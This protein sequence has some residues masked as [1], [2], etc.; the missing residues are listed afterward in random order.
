MSYLLKVRF[1]RNAC[2]KAGGLY[3]KSPPQ[4]SVRLRLTDIP[5]QP[6]AHESKFSALGDGNAAVGAGPNPSEAATC[7][8]GVP[9]REALGRLGA[10]RSGAS[11][12]LRG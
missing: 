6:A 12:A 1:K 2:S 4:T 5:I 10:R 8:G 9:W 7:A 11:P 3:W